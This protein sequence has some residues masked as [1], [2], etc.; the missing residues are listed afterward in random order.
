MSSISNESSILKTTLNGNLFTSAYAKADDYSSI[1]VF[2][3]SLPDTEASTDKVEKEIVFNRN[4]DIDELVK[5]YKK[6]PSKILDELG[7]NFS[8]EQKKELESLINDKKSLKSFLEIAKQD[9]LNATDIFEGMK[10]TVEK[11]SSG[12][13]KRIGNVV[14]TLFKEGVSEAVDLAKSEKVYYADKLGSNMNEIREERE[15]FSSQGIANVAQS[16]TDT[17]EIKD[18]TMHFVQKNESAGKKLYSETDVTRAVEIME[19]APK[20][21]DKFCAN[22]VELEAVKDPNNNIKYKG[23]TIINVSERMTKN[24]DLKSTMLAIAKKSDMNDEYLDNTTD[25]LFKNPNMKDPLLFSAIAKNKDGS[26]KFKAI[27]INSISKHLI[28]KDKDYC[29][30]YSINLQDLSKY[31]KLKSTDIIS[32]VQDVTLNPENKTKIL[33]DYNLA[34]FSSDSENILQAPVETGYAQQHNSITDATLLQN[35][36][37]PYYQAQNDNINTQYYSTVSID[38]KD[39]PR[40]SVLIALKR[41]YGSSVAENMLS[42]MENNPKFIEYVKQYGDQKEIIEALIKDETKVQKLKSASA[43]IDNTKLAEM[44]KL[45]TNETSTNNLIAFTEKYGSAT[46][47]KMTRESK[48]NNAEEATANILSKSTLDSSTKKEKIEELLCG[49]AKKTSVQ[50]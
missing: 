8:E 11:K 9:K 50:S 23:S 37:M 4:F 26:D 10:K 29:T 20:E 14:K 12:F 17:P 18:S 38:G 16:V 39:Y 48:F 22:A 1:Q 25:N 7:I 36:E 44:L 24:D 42:K 6:D 45:A 46:A 19:E 3:S 33:A 49:T 32:A 35:K 27:D 28:T 34:D 2:N 31:D 47:I 15:D 40:N 43:S 21:A 30:D 13:F 5:K 41:R